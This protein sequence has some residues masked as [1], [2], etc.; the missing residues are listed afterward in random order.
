MI[1]AHDPVRDQAAVEVWDASY[2]LTRQE[3]LW[4]EPPVPFAVTTAHLFERDGAVRV[5]DLPC[6]DGRNIAPIASR[7]HEVVGA[8]SSTNA[9][10]IAVRAAEAAEVGNA[11]FMTSN[12]FSTPFLTDTFDGIFCC[13]VLGHLEAPA[14]ALH[15][16]LRVLRPGKALVANVFALGDS[17]RGPNMR[18]IGEE[19]YTFD[20]RFYFHY[21]DRAAIDDLLCQVGAVVERVELVRWTEP[22]HEGYREYEH[23]HE[24]W[25]FTLRKSQSA[26][27]A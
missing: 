21:Y 1:R 19:E 12:I 11:L 15:E 17:T 5:L 23:E 8:D 14:D 9:L 6:G 26:A 13:D 25:V 24:S 2:L 16:L 27:S 20:E 7:V 22:P 4:G 10:T 18:K 3:N